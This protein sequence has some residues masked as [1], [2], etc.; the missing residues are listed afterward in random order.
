MELLSRD[1]E[2]AL[3]RAVRMGGPEGDR[4]ADE[5]VVRNVWLARHAA[6]RCRRDL[7]FDDAEGAARLG[8]IKAARRWDAD[9]GVRFA[10][11][12]Y[13]VMRHEIADERELSMPAIPMRRLTRVRFERYHAGASVRPGKHARRMRAAAAAY[14]RT[15]EVAWLDDLETPIDPVDRREGPDAGDAEITALMLAE[16]ERLPDR[17]RAIVRRRFGFEGEPATMA[18]IG[19]EI[20]LTRE[21]VR[22][23]EGVALERL[24]DALAGRD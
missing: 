15:R 18:A 4:A 9:R 1:E 17:E 5:L 20:G 12:A 14:G 19:L 21:R 7:Q 23:L 16:L 22:Q 8:L 6:N 2:A 11:Y 10:T 13:T 3:G 24:R